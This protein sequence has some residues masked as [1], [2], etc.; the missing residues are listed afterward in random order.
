MRVI[1]RAIVLVFGAPL[2]AEAAWA[3]RA[4]AGPGGASTAVLEP[5]VMT[6]ALLSLWAAGDE[7]PAREARDECLYVGE[8][9]RVMSRRELLEGPWAGEAGAQG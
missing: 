7:G 9:G 2:G 5:G 4:V 6:R 1:E 3:A 8:A